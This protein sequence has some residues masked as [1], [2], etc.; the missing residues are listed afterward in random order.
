MKEP[1]MTDVCKLTTMKFFFFDEIMLIVQVQVGKFGVWNVLL[2][3][4]SDVNIILKSLRKKHGLRKPQPTM[5]VKR[6]ANPI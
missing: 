2:N 1:Q 5:F 4:G 3:G 6:M